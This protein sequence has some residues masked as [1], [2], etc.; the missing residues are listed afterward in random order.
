MMKRNIILC[1]LSPHSFLCKPILES[2]NCNVSGIVP[3]N[4][5]SDLNLSKNITIVVPDPEKINTIQQFDLDCKV[6]GLLFPDALEIS[7][8]G[9]MKCVIAYM[10]SDLLVN[11]V[12]KVRP[13]ETEIGSSDRIYDIWR[14]KLSKYLETNSI[15]SLVFKAKSVALKIIDSFESIKCNPDTL[16]RVAV[17]SIDLDWIRE[18]EASGYIA[19][20]SYVLDTIIALRKKNS[21]LNL[22]PL[23]SLSFLSRVAS[24]SRARLQQ[25]KVFDS[26]YEDITP[27]LYRTIFVQDTTID[28]IIYYTPESE[29]SFR[30]AKRLQGAFEEV[31]II[32]VSNHRFD[33]AQNV[34]LI[35]DT[36]GVGNDEPVKSAQ[37]FLNWLLSYSPTRKG[38]KHAIFGIGNSAFP[39]YNSAAKAIS[40][41]L[42]V[43][44]DE[45]LPLNHGDYMD[46]M[47]I[48]FNQWTEKL[49]SKMKIPKDLY[50][51][52]GTV[53]LD[54]RRISSKNMNAISTTTNCALIS[55]DV[56]NDMEIEPGDIVQIWWNSEDESLVRRD[57]LLSNTIR[58]RLLPHIDNIEHYCTDL[59]IYLEKNEW[60]QNTLD[61]YLPEKIFN[62]YYVTKC[63][64]PIE[65]YIPITVQAALSNAAFI[66]RHNSKLKLPQPSL[67]KQTPI[68]MIANQTGIHPFL[69]FISSDN[70]DQ[71]EFHLY[72]ECQVMSDWIYDK[73]D[74]ISFSCTT[75]VCFS[76]E[77]DTPSFIQDEIE[78]QAEQIRTMFHENNAY[79]YICGDKELVHQVCNVLRNDVFLIDR[80]F[81]Q[82]LEKG[83]IISKNLCI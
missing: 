25:S 80:E 18:V 20:T 76:D 29:L 57:G 42:R 72:Y 56:G 19:V 22:N 79:L 12:T 23:K 41:R 6:H 30:A 65:L 61:K 47:V 48:K 78:Y 33:S 64:S 52:L 62:N 44:S 74:G 7:S 26:S 31:P 45:I 46:Q 68:I 60:K 13:L 67:S 59:D 49:L 66:R 75:T 35:I 63:Q 73:V 32:P 43:I 54:R 39:N 21:D 3:F 16:P 1:D 11:G 58:D 2:E 24:W 83:R 8:T 81:E 82:Y 9:Y 15:A 14:K 70:S 77:F 71:Y 53:D 50:C 55:I 4:K 38:K 5:I 27:A 34:I 17:D 40:K 36:F 10:W 51:R 37:M 28:T 69:S